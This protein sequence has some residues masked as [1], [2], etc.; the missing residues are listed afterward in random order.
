M[1]ALVKENV[2]SKTKSCHT[3]LR[4]WNTMKRPNLR[5]LAIEK[6]QET[7]VKSPELIF[8]KVIEENFHNLKKKMTTKIQ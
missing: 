5:V 7:Q 1:D 4:N 2:T 3:T 6:G 8:N